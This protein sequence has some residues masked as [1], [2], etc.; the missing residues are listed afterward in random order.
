VQLSSPFLYQEQAMFAV[1]NDLPDLANKSEIV[2]TEA[3][4]ESLVKLLTAS[5]GR[6]IVL[7]TSHYQ[8]KAVYDLIK[9]PLV[10]Q[11]ITVLAHGITGNP[12]LLLSRLKKEPNCCILG[13]N[14]FWEGIDVVG[15]ALSLVIVVRLPFWPP[16]HPITAARQERI[17]QAGGNSFRDYSLPQAIIRFKQG[18]GRL[19]RSAEDMGVFCVLDR[20]IFEKSYGRQFYKA[21]PGMEMICDDSS[22]VAAAVEKWLK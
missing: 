1:C 13:A 11:G 5:K 12:A 21:L 14:S 2:C 7:F 8:L 17:E 19:I 18:F 16:N 3:I 4:A 6:A 15:S 22:E 20:R 10:G 9:K